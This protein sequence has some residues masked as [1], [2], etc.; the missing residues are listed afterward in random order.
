MAVEFKEPKFVFYN[1]EFIIGHRGVNI[2]EI[3]Y[4]CIRIKKEE[5]N[6]FRI[7]WSTCKKRPQKGPN[8]V[9]DFDFLAKMLY[10]VNNQKN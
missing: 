1:F 5:L 4:F 2:G 9:I 10:F 6:R 8:K 7:S 3:V